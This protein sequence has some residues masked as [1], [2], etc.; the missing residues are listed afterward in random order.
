MRRSEQGN[1][2]AVVELIILGFQSIPEVQFILFLMFLVA[3]ITTLSGNL[4]T[5]VLVVTDHHLH[6]RMFFFLGNLSFLETCYTSTTLP[7]MLVSFLTNKYVIS[8]NG[9]FL[10]YFFFTVLAGAE[11]CLLTAMS[12]D[13]Y[14]AICK[15]LRY[16]AIMNGRCCLQL[17]GGSW[18]NGFLAS[19][20]V[21]SLMP[22]L[23]FCGPN[24]VDHFFCD[25]MPV[26]KLSCSDTYWIELVTFILACL[27]TLLPF[28]LMLIS[29]AYISYTVLR[30]PS[31]TG[32]HKVLC[33]CSSHLTVVTLFYGTL[34]VVY[35]VPKTNTLGHLHKVFSVCYTVLTLLVN[36]F[37]YS[38]RNNSIKKAL[39]RA[40]NKYIFLNKA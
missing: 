33:T 2:T 39:R 5:M 8:C 14:I 18:V 6:S 26:V 20:I 27:L 32:R 40:V 12:Y 3:Y 7:K 15:P 1:E 29:Y 4:L 21:T 30:I 24:E 17:A 28:L 36:P 11:C 35:L 31:C 23:T 10:Q 34:M 25:F 38:L 13:R 16:T 37:I 9:C 22:Q 19:A